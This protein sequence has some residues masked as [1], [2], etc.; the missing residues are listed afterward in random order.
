MRRSS[1]LRL[2]VPGKRFLCIIFSVRG[3]NYSR[4]HGKTFV[5]YLVISEEKREGVILPVA[6][7]ENVGIRFPPDYEELL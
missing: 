1:V 6:D 4:I 7:K 3:R 5:M 2:K